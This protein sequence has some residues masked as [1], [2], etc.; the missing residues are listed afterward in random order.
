MARIKEGLNLN[1][2]VGNLV[3]Y[4]RNG[5]NYVRLKPAR[6]RDAKTETQLLTRGRFAGCNYFY[7]LI[8]TDLLRLVW[9]MAA[10]GTGKN[11]KNMFM[12]YNT[13][14]FGKDGEIDD[15]SRLHFSA[16]ML[17]LPNGLEMA[18]SD[19]RECVLQWKYDEQKGLGSA[20]DRL[21][22]VEVVQSDPKVQIHETGIRRSEGK[23]LFSTA[24]DIDEHTHFYCFFGNEQATL[25]SESYYLKDIQLIEP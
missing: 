7:S 24:Y 3:F 6:Y 11:A 18:Q 4:Q 15:Y 5:V 8:K 23:A 1:G 2:T 25:F 20:H 22:M 21:Y 19:N 13:Y 16:G 12:Q 10:Q 17:P 9:K 14:A